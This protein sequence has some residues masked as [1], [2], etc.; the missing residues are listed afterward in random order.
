MY[1]K[2]PDTF[3]KIKYYADEKFDEI[4][5]NISSFG[6]VLHNMM[7]RVKCSIIMCENSD[8]L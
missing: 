5:L 7:G 8:F 4:E 6:N 1:L 3:H 2:A